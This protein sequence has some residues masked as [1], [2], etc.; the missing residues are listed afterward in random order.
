MYV[1]STVIR[2]PHESPVMTV[3]R[4]GGWISIASSPAKVDKVKLEFNA[5]K[6]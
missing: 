1:Q 6:R 3:S 5:V 4:E 2:I